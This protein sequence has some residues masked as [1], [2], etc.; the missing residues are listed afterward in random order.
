MEKFLSELDVSTVLMIFL[1]LAWAY[2]IVSQALQNG[3]RAVDD[4]KKP[5]LRID[6]TIN[7][8][9]NKCEMHVKDL[10]DRIDNIERRLGEHDKAIKDLHD[11]QSVLCRGV[12]A[13]L[14]HALHNGNDDEMKSASDGI[15]KWLRTR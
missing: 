13:L 14:D 15:G 3:K 1:A 7:E 10:D 11:G 2:N 6:G 9:R 4:S 5:F 8:I 12:Q